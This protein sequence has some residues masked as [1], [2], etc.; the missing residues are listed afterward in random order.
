[1]KTHARL[2]AFLSLIFLAAPFAS[3]IAGT[4]PISGPV[5]AEEAK[6][7]GMPEGALALVNDPRRIHGEHPWF[8][9]LPNAGRYFEYEIKSMD[10]VNQLVGLLGA[11]K[12]PVVLAVSPQADAKRPTVGARLAVISQAELDA[13]FDRLTPD[14]RKKFRTEKRPIAPPM[15][16]TLYAGHAKVD[17]KKLVIPANVTLASGVNPRDRQDAQ[18]DQLLAKEIER[19]EAYVAE[20]KKSRPATG[21]GTPGKGN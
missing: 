1:M 6:R 5:S 8:S 9:E 2:L 4:D 11:I 12:S 19:V 16:L 21:P 14:G 17:L 18:H 13:W 3:A 20:V 15:T 10:D 7:L